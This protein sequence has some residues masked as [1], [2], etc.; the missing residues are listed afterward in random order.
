MPTTRDFKTRSKID[1]PKSGAKSKEKTG[2]KT[3]VK[4]ATA[5]GGKA[6][7]TK[8]SPVQSDSLANETVTVIPAAAKRRPGRQDE[9][10][11]PMEDVM[12]P[13]NENPKTTPN[14]T[15]TETTAT[16]NASAKTSAPPKSESVNAGPSADEI[17]AEFEA[18]SDDSKIE[19]NFAGSELLRARFPKPFE[20]AEAV[21]T[22]W[23]K[24]G[25]FDHLPIT[26]PL[27]NWAAQQGLLKAKELEKKVVESPQFEKAAMTTL[28]MAMKA[29]AAFEQLRARVKR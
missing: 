7:A 25:K 1:K 26:H 27:A 22:D 17:A 29:Q 15:G 6:P 24:D 8:R 12:T 4:S 5:A 21:A 23:L 18:T 20:V 10:P 2:T 19:I 9:I 14:D 16:V 13:E 28:T 3:A 11:T